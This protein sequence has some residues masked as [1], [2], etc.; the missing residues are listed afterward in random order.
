MQQL[1][2]EQ[3]SLLVQGI[4]IKSPV[5]RKCR[6]SS[7]DK[8][9]PSRLSSD[10]SILLDDSWKFLNCGYI[11]ICVLLT[12][13]KLLEYFSLKNPAKLD[14]FSLY[15]FWGY[16]FRISPHLTL[17][18]NVKTREKTRFFIFTDCKY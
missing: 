13:S 10:L 15:F 7:N 2:K 3:V 11:E 17:S 9:S 16:G 8:S 5:R 6:I 1:I 4:V 12:E 14:L 18:E